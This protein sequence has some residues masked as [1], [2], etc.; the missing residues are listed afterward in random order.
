MS[1][2]DCAELFL[3]TGGVSFMALKLARTEGCKVKSPPLP[4]SSDCPITSWN[5]SDFDSELCED[6]RLGCGIVKINGGISVHI[7][8]ENGGTTSLLRSINTTAKRGIFIQVLLILGSEVPK[9]L[10]CCSSN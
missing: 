3:G 8:I 2:I 5:W 1:V 6:S 10:T 7:V 4:T 9:T